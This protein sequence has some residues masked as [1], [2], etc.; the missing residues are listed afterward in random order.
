MKTKKKNNNKK[1]MKRKENIDK[2]AFKNLKMKFKPFLNYFKVQNLK[3][4]EVD[5]I[6]K[7]IS[8]FILKLKTMMSQFELRHE[9]FACSKNRNY[10]GNV[11]ITKHSLP[12]AP[13]KS[14]EE[15]N[16]DKKRNNNNNA[17]FET[18]IATREPPRNGQKKY[19]CWAKTSFTRV[20][21]HSILC[22]NKD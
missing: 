11:T 5:F 2:V 12:E 1:K 9:I 6:K 3:S 17:T 10:S 14:D 16:N 15:R 19:N 7:K 8:L 21:P 20:K 4:I 13:K 22:K 18:R